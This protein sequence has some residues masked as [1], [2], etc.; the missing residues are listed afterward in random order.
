[1]NK[2]NLID[3]S[4]NGIKLDITDISENNFRTNHNKTPLHNS[5]EKDLRKN[6]KNTYKISIFIK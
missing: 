5:R 1:M 2:F 6:N 4:I 3:L